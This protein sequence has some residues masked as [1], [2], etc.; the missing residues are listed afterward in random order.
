[1]NQRRPHRPETIRPRQRFPKAGKKLTRHQPFGS[2]AG[3]VE[4]GFAGQH[5]GDLLDARV[6]LSARARKTYRTRDPAKVDVFDYIERFDNPKRRHS[7][8]GYLSPTEFEKQG[9]FA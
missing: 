8:L 1:V 7:T 5:A 3:L 2:G 4:D 9:S 6:P